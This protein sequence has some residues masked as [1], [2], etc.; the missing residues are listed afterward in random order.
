MPGS[1]VLNP[2]VVIKIAGRRRHRRL[3]FS[4]GGRHRWCASGCYWYW[5]GLL[6]L[7]GA[8]GEI[9]KSEKRG[10]Y[11]YVCCVCTMRVVR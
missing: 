2:T 1:V 7:W 4:G 11:G 8:N 3:R 9:M 6:V 10:D 5:D